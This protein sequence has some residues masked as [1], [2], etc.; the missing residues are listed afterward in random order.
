MIYITSAIQL[1][2]VI[3]ETFKTKINITMLPPIITL[4]LHLPCFE[5]TVYLHYHL[6]F[7]YS[8]ESSNKMC[9]SHQE[10]QRGILFHYTPII[11]NVQDTCETSINIC[12]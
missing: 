2:V 10:C 11:G 1:C 5:Q 7:L 4:S 9:Q 8:R 12:L 6:D 3:L